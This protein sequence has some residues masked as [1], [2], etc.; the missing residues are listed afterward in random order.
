ME[1]AINMRFKSRNIHL[2]IIIRINVEWN[3]NSEIF[4]EPCRNLNPVLK[5]KQ[6]KCEDRYFTPPH[7][8]N[9]MQG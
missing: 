4:M 3:V 2:E 6:P 8:K 5:L 7:E 9:L 1:A